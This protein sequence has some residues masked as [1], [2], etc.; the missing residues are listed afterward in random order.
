MIV[1]ASSN[2]RLCSETGLFSFISDSESSTSS[3]ALPVSRDDL[4]SP[5]VVSP[6]DYENSCS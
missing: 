3:E 6:T 5:V 4:Y 2:R 1:E